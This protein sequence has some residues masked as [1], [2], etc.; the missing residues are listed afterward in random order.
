MT[1]TE[2]KQTLNMVSDPAAR[3]ELVMDFGKYLEPVPDGAKC[4]E[5]VGCTSLVE[6]CNFNGRLYGRADSAIVRG[7]VA[8]LLA[9]IDEKTFAQI[10]KMDLWGEFQ[11]LNLQLGT[12]R[13]GGVN[14]SLIH[15]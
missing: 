7:I 14:L 15:I 1:Y 12:G 6:I 13:V 9:M 2:M 4:S 8:L 3:L 10:K 5:I 11:S